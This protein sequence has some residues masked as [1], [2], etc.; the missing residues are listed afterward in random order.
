VSE[1]REERVEYEARRWV[2]VAEFAAYLG[3]S[4]VTAYKLAQSDPDVKRV[5]KR[6]GRR[7]LICL[8]AFQQ[9]EERKMAGGAA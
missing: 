5:T 9:G 2:S 7:V 6:F 4:R 1:W 3:V 8:Y